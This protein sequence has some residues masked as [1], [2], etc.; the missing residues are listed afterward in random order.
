MQFVNHNE[1]IVG[2]R[3]RIKTM[4][5]RQ[6]KENQPVSSPKEGGGG[7][8]RNTMLHSLGKRY[9]ENNISCTVDLLVHQTK[10]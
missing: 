5:R 9:F 3:R 8:T 7:K 2:G 4:G 6:E 1:I 10:I